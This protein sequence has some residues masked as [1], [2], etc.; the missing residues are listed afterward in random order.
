MNLLRYFRSVGKTESKINGGGGWG[1]NG[2][3]SEIQIENPTWSASNPARLFFADPRST[4]ITTGVSNPSRSI[5]LAL[6]PRIT[7]LWSGISYRCVFI[8]G[9]RDL[10][11]LNM[12]YQPFPRGQKISFDIVNKLPCCFYNNKSRPLHSEILIFFYFFLRIYWYIEKN[13]RFN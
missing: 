10:L 2:D 3:W 6:N 1:V 13:M 12:I 7:R 8:D 11:P 5:V 9:C 4:P